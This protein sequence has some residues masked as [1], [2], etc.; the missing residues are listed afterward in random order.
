METPI[1]CTIFHRTYCCAII[2]SVFFFTEQFLLHIPV[3]FQHQ[4]KQL[5]AQKRQQELI[6]RRKNE[7][8]R[9]S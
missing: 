3:T 5:E 8:V 4:V 2:F 6:L 1:I 9:H 7:E